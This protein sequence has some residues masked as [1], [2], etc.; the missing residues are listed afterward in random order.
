MNVKTSQ[1]QK[2][3][4]SQKAR[5]TAGR[6]AAVQGVYQMLANGQ[7]AAS[8]IVDMK[9]L[10]PGDG[11]DDAGKMV[12]PDGALM[13]MIIN[14]VETR[15]DDLVELITGA[16]NKRKSTADDTTLALPSLIEPL[17]KAI[18]LCGAYEL[19][20]HHETDVPLIITEYLDV[21]HA[22]YDQG[23]SKLVNG[24]LDKIGKNVRHNG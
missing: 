2:T 10:P 20:A 18:L 13:A 19:L 4:G 5:H 6:L 12:T 15:K 21:T 1:K 14:G 7:S 16:Q 3:E 8:V 9:A 23:E 22:F 11:L 24:I 17:L